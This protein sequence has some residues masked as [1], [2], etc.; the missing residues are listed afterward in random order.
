M[1]VV[2]NIYRN[3]R[4]LQLVLLAFMLLFYGLLLRISWRILWW[5]NPMNL[6]FNS[7]LEHLLHG[8]F[9]VDPQTVSFEGFVRGGRVYAYWGIW[10]ALLRLPLWIFRRMDVDM[11]MW[12]CLAAVCL[13][14]MAKVRALLLL[15]RHSPQN[16]LANQAFALLL[17]YILLAGGEIGYLNVNIYQEVVHWAVAFAAIF[18]YFAVKG[19]VNR[20]FDDKALCWMA[21]CA[22]L[23]VLTRVSTGI[24]LLLAIGLL[25]LVLAVQAARKAA[26]AA[27][28]PGARQFALALVQRR[29]LF[30]LG[31]AAVFIGL[32]GTVN[33]FR[34]GNPATFLDYSV[35]LC[36]KCVGD[37]M[38]RLRMYGT[39][40]VRRIPLGVQ[41]YFFPVWVFR[42]NGG[43]FFLNAAQT[44]LFNTVE[45]PPS[46]FFVEDLL[47]ICFVV[48][49]AIA[50]WRRRSVGLPPIG[51]AAAAIAIGL[52][53]PAFLMFM[54][55]TM[56]YRYRMEFYPEFDFLAF[57]GLYL[58]L[59][60]KAMLAM[61]ARYRKWFSAALAVS[62]VG[63]F[64]ALGMYDVG[65]TAAT[66]R[67]MPDGIVQFYRQA[68]A[69]DYH[70][71]LRHRVP[72]IVDG[73]SRQSGR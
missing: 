29:T 18:V 27:R 69:G 71:L 39:F 54:A 45:L 16:W 36:N 59:T 58:T 49:L 40:N 62:I 44:R 70:R 22:G 13:A 51:Q 9:D 31:I 34:W 48:L 4:R 33:Y 38:P 56:A 35:Y 60:D 5:G 43:H 14:G 57:L 20:S 66:S 23:A 72:P 50:L 47:P 24:G 11:T 67:D 8:R 1:A 3:D 2:L 73:S 6:T 17:V 19:I 26:M 53:A 41:Y 37:W 65:A 64:A 55:S 32:T 7:M 46:T 25:L 52:L 42:G 21:L 28:W 63:S 12:S 15:R 68:A 10:C 30:P 61:F